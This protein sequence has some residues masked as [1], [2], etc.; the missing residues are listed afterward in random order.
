M[1]AKF[2]QSRNETETQFLGA[3]WGLKKACETSPLLKRAVTR[4]IAEM[5][6]LYNKLLKCHTLYCKA[7]S[8]SLDSN[9][10]ME[11]INGKADKKEEVLSVAETLLGE[12]EEES[13]SKLAKKMQGQV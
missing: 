3:V 7:A 8:I 6:S 13:S 4:K 9:E 10:S 5:E 11:Y 2:K 12:N 1:S